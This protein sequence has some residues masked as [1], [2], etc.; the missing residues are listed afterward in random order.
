[1]TVR[2]ADRLDEGLHITFRPNIRTPV[3]SVVTAQ[4]APLSSDVIGASACA[5]PEVGTVPA[6]LAAWYHIRPE[7]DDQVNE[8]YRDK[9]VST[10]NDGVVKTWTKF[11]MVSTNMEPL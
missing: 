8:T 3:Y 11:G 10:T 6:T 5:K 1:M 4:V 7:D 2:L 9:V